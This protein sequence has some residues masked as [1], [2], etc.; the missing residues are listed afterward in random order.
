MRF[1]RRLLTNFEWLVPLL[2]IG[3][4]GLG[5]LTVYSATYNPGEGA[6]PLALRQL[7]WFS[8]GV[9]GMRSS[10]SLPGTRPPAT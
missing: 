4:C 10:T 1:D 5:M 6:S 9:A 3:V 7:V 2:A 8:A